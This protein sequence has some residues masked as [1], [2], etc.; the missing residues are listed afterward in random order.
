MEQI[1]LV[2]HVIACIGLVG[3]IL[4]QQGKGAEVGASFGSGA[5]QTIFGS[6]GSG[7]FITRITGIFAA[8]FFITS[9]TLGYMSHQR[10]LP[11][12]SIDELIN[13]ATPEEQI[14]KEGDIPK[15]PGE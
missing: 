5:S 15:I 8:V 13:K 7:S 11:K 1:I 3:L 9:L 10:L 6:A 14:Q 2:L 12:T 4:I